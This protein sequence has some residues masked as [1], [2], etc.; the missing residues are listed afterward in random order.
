MVDSS[1]Q[2]VV[3]GTFHPTFL[4]ECL[5]LLVLALV[6]VLLDRRRRLAPGQLLGVYVAGYPL[7]RIVVERMRTDDAELVLGQRVNVW[8]SLVVF[9]LG[10]WIIWYTG[11]RARRRARSV[12][13]A[14]LAE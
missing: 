8:T 12:E 3:L 11:R 5:F 6:L 4:Y 2:P 10:V 7:G 1:G 9:A 14:D 13:S